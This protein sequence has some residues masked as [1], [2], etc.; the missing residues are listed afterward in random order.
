MNS[1][2]IFRLGAVVFLTWCTGCAGKSSAS[3]QATPSPPPVQ[4]VTAHDGTIWP[5]VQIAGVIAPYREVAVTADLSEPIA[6]VDVVEGQQVQAGQVLARLLTDD[7]EA[8]LASSEQ[9]ESEDAARY[10]QTVYQTTATT[11]QNTTSVDAAR[12]SVHQA[13][14]NLDGAVTDLHRYQQLAS[15]GYLPDQTLDQQRVTVAT[16]RQALDAA[17]AT[18]AS[19][20][21]NDT[22][23]GNGANAGIQQQEV[24]AAREAVNAALASVNQLKLEIARAVIVAPVSGTVE[25]VNANPG[26]YPSG[27]QLFTLEQNAQ[28]YALLPASSAQV[29]SV[30][31]GA[32]ASIEV[33]T[34]YNANAQ[35]HKDHGTVDAILDQIEPGT[36]NFI[37]KVLV[38]NADAHLHAGMPVT[39][40]VDLPPLRGVIVPVT[41]FID[42][43]RT[44]LYTVDDGV[45]H[46]K[47]VTEVGDDGLNAVVTG[48]SPGELVVKDVNDTTVGN[49]DRVRP[50]ATAQ[51]TPGS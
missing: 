39:G 13:Q 14:V 15:R 38:G 48:V 26:E 17:R 6:E 11:A 37:V 1:D 16:D 36:T 49:G 25:S 30:R 40:W 46:Q 28:V 32:A 22:V 10:A 34:S 35:P 2:S 20:L 42:D 31:R 5:S 21:V 27:R 29:L 23:N 45:V 33:N 24:E 43:T 47:S 50:M 41:A 12:D 4:T 51:P 7:L 9:V 8:Q 19:A 44:T 3:A 18:L